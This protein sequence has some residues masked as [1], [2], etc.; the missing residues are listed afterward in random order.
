MGGDNAPVSTVKGCIEAIKISS[1]FTVVLI[2]NSEKI[3]S[4]LSSEIYDKDRI[5]IVHTSEIIECDDV[6]TTSIREKK[7]SSMVVGFQ[8]LKDKLGDAFI[9]AGNS[10]ALMVGAH[11]ILGRIK[12]VNRPALAAVIPSD[13]GGCLIL[14]VGLNTMAKPLNI[15]QFAQMGSIYYSELFDKKN[16]EIG[17]INVGTEE[18]KGSETVK[19]AFDLLKA[20]DLNF[21][22]NIESKEIFFNRCDIAVCDGFTGNVMLKTIEG[23]AKYVFSKIRLLLNGKI[24]NKLAGLILKNDLRKFRGTMDADE[25]GGAPLLGVNGLVIKSHGNSKDTTIKNVILKTAILA[26]KGFQEKLIKF[27]SEQKT[28]VSENE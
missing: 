5:E 10:G 26:E 17:L 6:P 2:G 8:M 1:G 27:F 23:T 21:I 7:D 13:R 14:D 22:G 28:E 9:S 3:N 20:S 24:A 18:G 4:I 12:G 15:F 16:P 25:N 11:L 19:A